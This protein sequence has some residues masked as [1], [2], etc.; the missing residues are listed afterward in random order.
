M[1]YIEERTVQKERVD[2][3][4]SLLP[5]SVRGELYSIAATRRDFYTA[6]S[7]IRIRRDGHSS[8]VLAGRSSRLFSRVGSED[9]SSIFDKVTEGSLYAYKETLKNGYLPLKYGVRLGVCGDFSSG[10]LIAPTSF[11]FRLPSAA[12]EVAE[13]LYSVWQET[14]RGMLIYS[15][16][17]GGKTSAL[18]ALTSLIS[19]RLGVRCVVIDERYE[20][21]PEECRCAD[22]L[23][24]Y[25]KAKGIEI[26]KRSLAAEV[27]IVDEIG[28]LEDAEAVL[29]VGRG[30]ASVIAT[31]HAGSM[32]E[33]EHSRAHKLL[34][35]AEYFSSAV[36]L[37][38][39][40]GKRGIDVTKLDSEP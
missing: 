31:A 24:G 12:C 3:I 28:S 34:L 25:S 19:E 38:T 8:V 14:R 39:C 27:V 4:A 7:E 23:R 9:F 20:F 2:Y 1:N 40:D 33:L 29:S 10:G 6:L 26:A 35:D 36:G 21:I 11:V 18:R 16:S 37:V 32:N 5:Q 22:I 13:E 15:V 17:G 30:G